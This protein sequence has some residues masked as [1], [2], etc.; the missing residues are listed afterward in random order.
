MSTF[1]DH[2]LAPFRLFTYEQVFR[3]NYKFAVAMLQA[4]RSGTEK[5]SLGIV[6]DQTPLVPSHFPRIQYHSGMGS[7][8]QVCIDEMPSDRLRSGAGRSSK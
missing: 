5:F 7:S 6:R 2:P 3:M 1:D 4:R 8:A